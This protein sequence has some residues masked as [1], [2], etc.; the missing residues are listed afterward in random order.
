MGR[1]GST[2]MSL[3]FTAQILGL[4]LSGLL[5]DRIGVRHVFGYCAVLLVLLAAVG[6]FL[7]HPPPRPAAAT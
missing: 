3:I 5:A 2:N 4:V 7:M 1:V 6:R